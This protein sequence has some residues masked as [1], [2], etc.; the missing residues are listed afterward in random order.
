MNG[1]ED[2]DTGPSRRTFFISV[3]AVT[4][5][6]LAGCLD[7]GSDDGDG[8]NNGDGGNDADSG[9]NT[10]ADDSTGDGE[11]AGGTPASANLT[12]SSLTEGYEAHDTGELP[13]IFDFEYPAVIGE[14]VTV[15]NSNNVAYSG[16]RDSSE[17]TLTLQLSQSTIP[18]SEEQASTD[19]SVAV[20]T[21]FNGET[22]EFYG[23]P[24]SNVL[25]WMGFLPYER[26]GEMR[27]FSVNL[28]L[29]ASG[30][31]SEECSEALQTAAE[32]IVQSMELNPDTTIE[33][34][35]AGQ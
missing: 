13:V 12:C 25:S 4:A 27:Y 14:F 34:E 32:N 26:D 6:G 16:S 21:E 35:Y 30:D 5:T 31:D 9:S 3:T 20:T 1:K 7:Q 28:A 18:L 19:Q 24:P 23:P 2:S 11:S 29:S 22:I 17:L 8:G 10:D 15:E 33:T